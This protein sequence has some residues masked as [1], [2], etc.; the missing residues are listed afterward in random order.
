M[1]FI[2]GMLGLMFGAGIGGFWGAIILGGAGV[3]FGRYIKRANRELNENTAPPPVSFETR[4]ETELQDFDSLRTEVLNLRR[5]IEQLEK[6]KLAVATPVAPV[7]A[8]V[9]PAPNVPAAPPAPEPVL[10]ARAAAPEIH[11]APVAPPPAPKVEPKPE[12]KQEPKPEFKP[13]PKPVFKPAPKPEFEPEDFKPAP[14]PEPEP[15]ALE[16]PPAPAE[17]SFVARLFSGNIVAKVGVVVLFFGVAFLL[18]F[19]YDRGFFPPGLRLLAVGLA[20]CAMFATGWWLRDSRRLY[21]LILQ[22]GAS[23]L[24]YLDV[25]FAL[26]MYPGQFISPV[27]GFILFAILGVATTVAAVRQ[28]ARVLAVLGLGGAFLAP[29]LA[30]TGAGNHVLLFSYYLLLNLFILGVSWFRAWR[31]LNLTG[32]GF[33]FAI[34]LFWGNANYRPELFGTVEPFVLAFFAIYLVVPI[35]FA[36]RQPPQLK[37]FV[38]G[39][40][41]FGTP[42]AVAYM[43]AGLVKGMPYGLAWS[44]A[45]GA[46]LYGLLATFTWRRENM[47][48]LAETYAALAV[49][50]GT[51]AAFFAFD[52]YPTFAFWTIEGAALL[53][54]GLRQDRALARAFAILVQLAGA[55]LFISEYSGIARPHWLLNDRIYGCL[56]ITVASLISARLL[57][58]HADK[59]RDWEKL[60]GP[61]LLLWGAFWWTIGGSDAL[62]QGFPREALPNAL[63]LFYLASFAAVEFGGRWRDWSGLRNLAGFHPLVLAVALL[64]AFELRQH[65]LSGLGWLTWPAGFALAFWT[66]RR[67]QNDG[68]AIASMPRYAGLWLVLALAA[69]WE[70]AWLLEHRQHLLG[71]LFAFAAHGAAWLRYRLRERDHPDARAGSAAVLLWAMFFWF[72]H[73]FVHA[74]AQFTRPILIT[75]MLGFVTASAL[76]YEL[77]GRALSWSGLRQASNVAWI[78]LPVAL[79]AQLSG[80]IHPFAELAWLGWPAAFAV[81]YWSLHRHERDDLAIA[82]PGKHAAGLWSLVIVAGLELSWQAREAQLGSAWLTSVWG[83]CA[84]AALW[85]AVALGDRGR[86]PVAAL[87]DT[88]RALVLGPIGA[89]AVAWALFANFKA[90]GSMAPL[91]YLPL[92]NPLD[93]MIGL[94]LGALWAWSR[95]FID[96]DSDKTGVLRKAAG[97]LGFIWLNGIA[98]RSI[99]YWAGVPYEFSAL[100]RSVL[101]QSTLSLLWTAAAMALMFL[102]RRRM[103]RGL[104]IAGAVLLGAV[105]AKLFLIDLANTGTVERIV[106][107]IGVGGLLLLIGYLAPVPPGEKTEPEPQR[108]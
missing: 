40:L 98:L 75:A 95:W 90:P 82:A 23:G 39:T 11:S 18:K 6:A 64:L 86:W 33:T 34:G 60:F 78:A 10:A 69:T 107:F 84:A 97:A 41:V 8:V 103:E 13:E 3:W 89:F 50:L 59:L 42:A 17:P 77:L 54:V 68:I 7:P 4:A 30:S 56:L 70:E 32:W 83:V 93:A 102:A 65:P 52:A 99:H 28:D 44:A 87:R 100:F 96:P 101:V 61:A 25:F 5:R 73:A 106:S 62:R 24:A 35:L 47:R 63:A 104:W 55:A 48:L 79:L 46:A 2:F 36:T 72:A 51:L 58:R 91:P 71:M 92:L 1:W 43:Q 57:A 88:Y 80:A 66:L 14:R 81:A 9:A 45:I 105:V 108:D 20:A 27:T 31:D 49:G 26:K 74:E 16:L 37:G 22:G 53:W 12:F 29:V 21:G 19:A 94:S 67:Q 76:A 38:D 15:E 85:A